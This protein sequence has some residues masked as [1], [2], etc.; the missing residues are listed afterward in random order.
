VSGSLRI[1]VVDDHPIVR[2]G[3]KQTLADASE[4]GEIVEAA[5]QHE[6]LDLVRQRE[7]DAV[8]LDIGLPGRGGLE[9]L[10]DIKQEAPRLPCS[11]SACL[12]KSN[13]P[14]GPYAPA[15]PATSR[16]RLPPR[17]SS[18]WFAGSYLAVGTSARS[19]AERLATELT[20]DATR[21]LHASLSDREL[22]TIRLPFVT[23]SSSYSRRFRASRFSR[24]HRRQRPGTPSGPGGRTWWCSTSTCP[25][26]RVSRYSKR[27]RRM[28]R[29]LR[30]SC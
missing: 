24:R 13:T 3:F 22:S 5:T 23:I 30:P 21:P 28:V 4:I 25:G 8:I 1:L 16:K 14:C 6:A 18:T 29:V 12:P 20:A 10:K 2:Q 7:W 19:A 11:S 17:S 26:V 9:V 15:R 27:C